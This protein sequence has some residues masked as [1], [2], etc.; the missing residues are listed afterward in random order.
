MTATTITTKGQIVIPSRI[1]KHLKIKAGMRIVLREQGNKIIVEP[2]NELLGARGDLV[3]GEADAF[4]HAQR[5]VG[6]VGHD[7]TEVGDLHAFLDDE[8]GTGLERLLRFRLVVVLEVRDAQQQV[9]FVDALR[10]AAGRAGP[11]CSSA[12]IAACSAAGVP[13][14]C[15]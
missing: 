15:V 4:F 6:A 7:G 8:A 14:A 3:G 2:V 9:G 1:R 5:V 11:S 13:A 10:A 12:R